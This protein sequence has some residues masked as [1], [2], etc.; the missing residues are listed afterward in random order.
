[1]TPP[2]ELH[3]GLAVYRRGDGAPVLVLPYPHTSGGGPMVEGR[4]A[5]VAVASGSAVVTFDP[6]AQ[7]R[8]TRPARVALDEMVACAD[9]TP[10]DEHAPQIRVPRWGS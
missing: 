5:P 7:Y 1:M 4:L 10:P 9:E 2:V 3:E 6:P 8:S